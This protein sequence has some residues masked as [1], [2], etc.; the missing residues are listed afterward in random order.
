MDFPTPIPFNELPECD[1]DDL[2]CQIERLYKAHSKELWAMLYAKFKNRERANDA[3]HEAFLRLYATG[4][5]EVKHPL[6]WMYRVGHNF[7]IDQ[8]RRDRRISEIEEPLRWLS[9]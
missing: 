3:V 2:I 1:D 7:L 9:G 4:I 6:R 8:K 5:Q